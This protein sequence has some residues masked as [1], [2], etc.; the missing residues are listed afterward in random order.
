ML[1]GVS[2]LYASECASTFNARKHALECEIKQLITFIFSQAMQMLQLS[3]VLETRSLQLQREV[4]KLINATICGTATT[5]LWKVLESF[6]GV[7]E[8]PDESTLEDAQSLAE[9]L[10]LHKE[11]KET[12]D[13][14]I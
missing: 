5:D 4:L 7:D 9:V 1:A 13:P 12:S 8:D 3:G 6:F 11:E 10:K 2:S 14:F